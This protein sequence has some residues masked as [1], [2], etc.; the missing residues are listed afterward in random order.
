MKTGNKTA[1]RLDD[2]QYRGLLNSQV[3]LLRLAH[4]RL[5]LQLVKE[6]QIALCLA[7]RLSLEAGTSGPNLT[8]SAPSGPHCYKSS[9]FET[10]FK[11][12]LN[13]GMTSSSA[14][15]DYFQRTKLTIHVIKFPESCSSYSSRL[16]SSPDGCTNVRGGIILA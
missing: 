16:R 2:Q 12:T 14:L 6:R 5:D 8:K 13:L 10:L 4:H 3:G 11:H 9:L 15:L 1:Y 7:Q